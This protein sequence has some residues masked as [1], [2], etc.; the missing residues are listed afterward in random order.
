MK[1]THNTEQQ[2]MYIMIA[3]DLFNATETILVE[4]LMTANCFCS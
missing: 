1:I 3:A 2:Y 4:N